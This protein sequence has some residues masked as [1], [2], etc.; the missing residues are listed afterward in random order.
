[1]GDVGILGDDDFA[2]KLAGVAHVEVA[3]VRALNV[4]AH[5]V[6]LAA[7]LA[8]HAARVVRPYVGL[9]VLLQRIWNKEKKK[10]QKKTVPNNKAELAL[11]LFTKQH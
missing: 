1:M 2:T 3:P 11:L 5:R 4:I 9:D 7:G 6:G 10:M 8:T